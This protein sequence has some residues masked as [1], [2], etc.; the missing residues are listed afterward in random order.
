MKFVIKIL[1]LADGTRTR[2]DNK[3]VKVFDPDEFNGRGY[4]TTTPDVGEAKQFDNHVE[5]FDF[6]QQQ[7]KVR[8]NRRDGQ[9]NRPLTAYNVAIDPVEG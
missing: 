9:P 2:F 1:C 7:S 4:L 6:W 3:F 5:A 8:P